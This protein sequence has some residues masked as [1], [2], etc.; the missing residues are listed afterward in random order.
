M[1]K[2]VG[3]DVGFLDPQAF[4]A[5]MVQFE[6]NFLVDQIPKLMN[7]DFMVGVYNPGGH[8]VLV[9]IVINW[10][11]VFCLDSTKIVPKQK[12]TNVQQVVNW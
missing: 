2:E 11:L 9:V 5:A 12:F 8:W 3:V 6:T 10:S 7:H 1:A 4:L